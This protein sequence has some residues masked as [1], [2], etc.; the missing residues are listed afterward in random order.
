MKDFEAYIKGQNIDTIGALREENLREE[1]N[2]LNSLA[3]AIEKK[4]KK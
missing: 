2:Y 1:I 3:D 4:V